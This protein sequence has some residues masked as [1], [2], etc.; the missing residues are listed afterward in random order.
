MEHALY[1]QVRSSEASYRK[2]E[3]QCQRLQEDFN[4]LQRDN[5]RRLKVWPIACVLLYDL[6]SLLV[7]T[8]KLCEL[9]GC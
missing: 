9:I 3:Q 2:Q 8:Q 6:A 1:N 7:G 5:A 4:A